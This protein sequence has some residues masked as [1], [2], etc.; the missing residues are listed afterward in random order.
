MIKKTFMEILVFYVPCP[1]K[2]T[3]DLLISDMLKEKLIACGNIIPVE[4]AYFWEGDLC[5]EDEYVIFLKTKISNEESIEKYLESQHPYETP[6][7]LRYPVV[8]N[9]NY[10]N[11]IMESTEKKSA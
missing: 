1:D 8:V 9:E 2:K 11:W 5:N 6:C 4:S 7:I 10:G 3:A